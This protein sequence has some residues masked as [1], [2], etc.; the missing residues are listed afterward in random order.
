M[1]TNRT[2]RWSIGTALLCVI[3]LAAFYFLLIS[4]RRASASDIR[5]QAAQANSQAALLQT[6]IAQLKVDFASLPTRKKEL[7][8]IAR[9]LPPN[10]DIPALIRDLQGLA[11]QS[12]VSLDSVTPGGASVLSTGSGGAA[13]GAA[14]TAGAAAGAPAAAPGAGTLI[15]VPMTVA[16]TGEYYE[17]SLFLKDLQTQLSRS[18]LIT[19]FSA[20]PAAALTIA[21]TGTATSTT[22]AST[23][24][25]TST[26]TATPTPTATSTATTTA[27]PPNLDRVTLNLTGSVFV[28]LDGTVT[29]DDV[30]AD[31]KAAAD[32][33][34][35]AGRPVPVATTAPTAT[36]S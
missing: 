13:A 8:A 27:A 31:A 35:K 36:A 21:T 14:G 15:T 24:T 30:A 25:G 18:F 22:A 23:P 10:A 26:A 6:K 34:K 19:G 28:L 12:G 16:V 29:L 11:A 17:A 2:S 7:A 5:E 32:A 33:A 20:A 3:L 4:P 9:H 1:L